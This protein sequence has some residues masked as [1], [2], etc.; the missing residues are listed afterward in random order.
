MMHAGAD[1]D[2]KTV[3]Q[4]AFGAHLGVSVEEFWLA[5]VG[6]VVRKG[7][8]RAEAVVG[9]DLQDVRRAEFADSAVA[10]EWVMVG[11]EVFDSAQGARTGRRRRVAGRG[12]T[13]RLRSSTSWNCCMISRLA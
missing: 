1:V 6:G 9:D 3:V 11:L 13:S 12:M 8:G 10:V 7:T 5:F 2:W 4:A